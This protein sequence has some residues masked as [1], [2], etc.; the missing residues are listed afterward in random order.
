ML[1]F[2]KETFWKQCCFFFPNKRL[3][4][5]LVDRSFS[6]DLK[7]GKKIKNVAHWCPIGIKS[8]VKMQFLFIFAFVCNL[9][10]SFV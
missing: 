9:P 7:N 5:Q 1:L 8:S 10:F 3:D 4:H 6:F 2:Q